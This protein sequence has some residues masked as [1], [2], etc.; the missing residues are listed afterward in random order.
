MSAIEPKSY[1][2]PEESLPFYEVQKNDD[3]DEGPSSGPIK[4]LSEVLAKESQNVQSAAKKVFDLKDFEDE[5]GITQ[6]NTSLQ[7]IVKVHGERIAN[8]SKMGSVFIEATYFLG[9]ADPI[10]NLDQELQILQTNHSFRTQ[11]RAK[12]I[13]SLQEQLTEIFNIEAE[14]K[15]NALDCLFDPKINLSDIA[16][17]EKIHQRHLS[18]V[19][20]MNIAQIKLISQE[21]LYLEEYQNLLNK[22]NSHPRNNIKTNL[23]L[24]VLDDVAECLKKIEFSLE[25]VTKKLDEIRKI[26]EDFRAK[27]VI[28]SENWTRTLW[29][30]GILVMKFSKDPKA[31]I[32]VAIEGVDLIR[33][34]VLKHPSKQSRTIM[35]N[36]FLVHKLLIGDDPNFE[37]LARHTEKTLLVDSLF[38]GYSHKD[39][40]LENDPD[41][42]ENIKRFADLLVFI[43][44]MKTMFEKMKEG[45]FL[46]LISLSLFAEAIGF[47]FA[48]IVPL[49]NMVFGA[50]EGQIALNHI[51]KVA[52]YLN[53]EQRTK[54]ASFLKFLDQKF[55]TM[56]D[57][58][59]QRILM[60]TFR[61][62]INM[63]KGRPTTH[64]F[65]RIQHNIKNF[66]LKIQHANNIER[67]VRLIGQVVIPSLIFLA[68]KIAVIA[69]FVGL[70]PIG[71]VVISAILAAIATV[72][73]GA[74]TAYQVG[75][76]L[77]RWI[78][79]WY[80]TTVKKVM[81]L[82]Q[83]EENSKKLQKF[84]SENRE[85]LD[86]L[87]NHAIGQVETSLK[88]GKFDKKLFSSN[89]EEECKIEFSQVSEEEKNDIQWRREKF[90]EKEKQKIKT[91]FEAATFITAYHL[92]NDEV[93]VLKERVFNLKEGIEIIDQ[94]LCEKS[95]ISDEEILEMAKE[96][97]VPF[98]KRR[99]EIVHDM[100][101][102][103]NL[104]PDIVRKVLV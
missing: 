101:A 89:F 79:E 29:D 34:Y 40:T 32:N 96:K 43:A 36:L 50:L 86:R 20:E 17:I 64:I 33:E 58:H 24:G 73:G 37:L 25:K 42:P 97:E 67:G 52:E 23:Q 69:A 77:S 31:A 61:E 11:K 80:N 16:D 27:N 14:P 98:N 103:P 21:R 8:R 9:F 95:S 18:L 45:S 46:P 60:A 76:T 85:I 70:A 66:C 19:D 102:D 65:K 87:I 74:Y 56:E 68:S 51:A 6:I 47:R 39:E 83:I 5:Y 94:L 7:N 15:R 72:V 44:N 55:S 92:D 1:F 49:S 75:Y 48:W 59:E 84:L 10:K 22:Y 91:R 13:V 41:M 62:A 90:L 82:T 38:R 26:H 93:R 104:W 30:F 57:L 35:N 3:G 2:P 99:L 53:Q 71:I 100:R 88:E 4:P 81:E 54:L 78:D 12:I 28:E 63:E